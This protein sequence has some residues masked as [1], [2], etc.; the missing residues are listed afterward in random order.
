MITLTYLAAGVAA[1]IIFLAGLLV[2][3]FVM[4]ILAMSA[5]ASD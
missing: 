5:N 4:G 3:A 1:G 2:G